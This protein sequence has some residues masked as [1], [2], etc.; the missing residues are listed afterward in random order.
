CLLAA[1]YEE[2]VAIVESKLEA[3]TTVEKEAF[4]GMNAFTIY[5]L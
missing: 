5:N 4:W 1:S 2:S 3:F